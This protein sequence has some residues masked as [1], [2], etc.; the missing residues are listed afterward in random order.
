MRGCGIRLA[1]M[2]AQP[3]PRSDPKQPFSESAIN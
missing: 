2:V 3:Y 1:F